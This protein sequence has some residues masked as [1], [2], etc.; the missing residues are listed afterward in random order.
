MAE[1]AA[2]TKQVE[3]EVQL[4]VEEATKAAEAEQVC[5]GVKQTHRLELPAVR[6]SSLF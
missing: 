1:E 2:R 4:A 6:S 5:R 3:L